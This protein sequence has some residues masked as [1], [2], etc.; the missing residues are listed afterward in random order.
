VDEA[1]GAYMARCSS[2]LLGQNEKLQGYLDACVLADEDIESDWVEDRLFKIN[3]VNEIIDLGNAIRVG[4]FKAQATRD[5]GLLS[6]VQVLFGEVEVKLDALEGVTQLAADLDN[7]EGC[8]EAARKYLSAM[9][10]FLPDWSRREE[11]GLRRGEQAAS[12]EETGSSLE[13]VAGMVKRNAENSAT[14]KEHVGRARFTGDAGVRDMEQMTVAMEAIQASSDEVAKI[15]KTID[16]IAFQ[17]NILALNAAV[18]AARAGEAA[19]G[20]AVVAD[21]VRTLAQ[22]AASAARETALRIEDAVAR[23]AHGAGIAVQVAERLG[24]IVNKAGEVAAASAEQS[25]GLAQI[26]TA[27]AEMDKLT[28]GNAASAEELN[29]QSAALREAVGRLLGLVDG[30]GEDG[31]DGGIC[32]DQEE[33]VVFKS[34]KQRGVAGYGKNRLAALGSGIPEAVGVRE[35]FRDFEVGRGGLSIINPARVS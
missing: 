2:Y 33:P 4:N 9:E 26:N 28:Q 27:V 10:A 22:R 19:K 12:L 16:E 8:R 13:E 5:P 3:L 1:A 25:D 6:E 14:L 35:S 34:R 17:T 31:V 24:E 30:G 15:I 7:I 29:A 23:S 32:A 21:E 20:F 11:L 18:E